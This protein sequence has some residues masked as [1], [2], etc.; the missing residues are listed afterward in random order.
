M[1]LRTLQVTFLFMDFTREIKVGKLFIYPT[2]TIYG[3]G[4]D[5]DNTA[6]VEKLRD[7]K[8]RPTNPFSVIAPSKGWIRE[9]CIV[10]E[11]AEEWLAKLP[12]PYTLILPLKRGGT[13]GI[14]IPD[15]WIKDIVQ[16]LDCPIITTSVNLAGE[17]PITQVQD[18]P[19]AMKR[20]IDFAI[21]DGLLSGRPSSIV[22]LDKENAMMKER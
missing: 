15:H 10:S 21:D 9:H 4:C 12:G 14:R 19:L 6:A 16:E 3:V 1:D 17:Q 7:M 18:V 20:Y 11:K 2:D 22:Y 8:K 5:A 13:L